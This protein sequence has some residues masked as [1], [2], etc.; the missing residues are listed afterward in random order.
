MYIIHHHS[1][2]PLNRT[3]QLVLELAKTSGWGIITVWQIDFLQSNLPC[4][5][6]QVNAIAQRQENSLV[7]GWLHEMDPGQSTE[8]MCNWENNIEMCLSPVS[9]PSCQISVLHLLYLKLKV[10]DRILNLPEFFKCE[11]LCIRRGKFWPILLNILNILLYFEL[12]ILRICQAH[13]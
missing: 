3:I 13:F 12:G 2:N 8:G 7:Q 4:I 10:D 9:V 1:L 5:P 6:R 11:I